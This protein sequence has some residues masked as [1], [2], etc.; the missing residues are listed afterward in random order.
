MT[1]SLEAPS[2]ACPV[3]VCYVVSYFHPFA[4][5]LD[6]LTM[7]Q[8]VANVHARLN[9]ADVPAHPDRFFISTKVAQSGR[10]PRPDRGGRS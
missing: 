3:R 9:D 4:S 8:F 6:N 10:A 5:I 1:P 7:P 2:T